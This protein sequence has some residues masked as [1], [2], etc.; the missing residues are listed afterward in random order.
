MCLSVKGILARFSKCSYQ[1]MCQ[2]SFKLTL[3]RG[4]NK[5]VHYEPQASSVTDVVNTF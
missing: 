5:E 1:M 3:K 4:V 2:I